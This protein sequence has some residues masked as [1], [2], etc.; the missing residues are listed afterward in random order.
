MAKSSYGPRRATTWAATE[1]QR[2]MPRI[3]RLGRP[4]NDNH[5]QPSAI[6]RAI[7]MG[8]VGVLVVLALAEWRLFF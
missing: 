2:P 4:A 7:V 3:V 5:R 6:K 8:F 1:N